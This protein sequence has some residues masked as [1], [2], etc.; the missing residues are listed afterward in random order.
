MQAPTD[1]MIA[2]PQEDSDAPLIRALAAG[3]PAAPAR[4]AE[5]FEGPLRAFLAR[6]VGD[7]EQLVDELVQDAL[8]AAWKGASRF[9]GRARVSTWVFA[10]ARRQAISALRRRRPVSEP[11]SE[12]L[13]SPTEPLADEFDDLHR[14]LAALPPAQRAVLDLTFTFGFSYKEIAAILDVPEGT[15]KSR[16]S[17]ARGSLRRALAPEEERR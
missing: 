2:S 6:Q 1:P 8:L 11:L 10:I 12:E 9:D 3:D 5:R 16:A 14:A 17:V 13:P 15:V 4:F 7:D